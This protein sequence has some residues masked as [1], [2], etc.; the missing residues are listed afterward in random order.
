[1]MP[2]T[3][4]ALAAENAKP[5]TIRSQPSFTSLVRNWGGTSFSRP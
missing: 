5:A 2:V 4:A 1:M 3:A